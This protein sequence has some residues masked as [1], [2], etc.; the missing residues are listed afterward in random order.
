LAKLDKVIAQLDVQP[1]QVLIEAVILNVTHTN[2]CDL[3]VN[4]GVVDSSGQVLSIVGKGAAINAATAFAPQS[5]LVNGLVRNGFSNTDA[6]G[7][8]GMTGRNVT[9]FIKALEHIG[10]VDVLAT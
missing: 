1:S 9:G 6:A 7:Q 10:K 3:G 4:F 8:F 5:V 2:S